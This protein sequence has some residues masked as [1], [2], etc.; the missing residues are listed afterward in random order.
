MCQRD[1]I[2][3]SYTLAKKKKNQKIK[4]EKKF[5]NLPAT[6]ISQFCITT[7]SFALLNAPFNAKRFSFSW[8]FFDSY[9][10]QTKNFFFDVW[11]QCRGLK[12][13]TNF[14]L[15]CYF[16]RTMPNNTNMSFWANCV[17]LLI[18][19]WKMHIEKFNTNIF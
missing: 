1:T 4:S 11:V 9:V 8:D 14:S 3:Q 15:G 19:V 7:T 17:N 18:A 12:L 13:T 5:A 2:L 6:S 16:S 10:M